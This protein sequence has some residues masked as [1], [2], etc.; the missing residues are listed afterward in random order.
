MAWHRVTAW[1]LWDTLCTLHLSPEIEQ[2]AEAVRWSLSESRSCYVWLWGWVDERQLNYRLQCSPFHCVYSDKE[3]VEL[4]LDWFVNT[5]FKFPYYNTP[6]TTSDNSQICRLK[7]NCHQLTN[8]NTITHIVTICWQ[9]NEDA[10]SSSILFISMHA[11]ENSSQVSITWNICT[12]HCPLHCHIAWK[13][14][15]TNDI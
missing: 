8:Q 1:S 14:Q 10:R 15:L 11:N 5:V 7:M 2:R 12:S 6:H 13:N 4:W 9:I 3:I